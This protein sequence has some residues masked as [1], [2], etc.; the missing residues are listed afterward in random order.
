[1]AKGNFFNNNEIGG[2]LDM[3]SMFG[4]E[5][6][7][8]DSK[9]EDSAEEEAGATEAAEDKGADT[10]PSKP[11]TK[12]SKGTKTL[13]GPVQVLA[14]GWSES[15]GEE[16]KKYSSKE[17]VKLAYE[18]GYREVA[19]ADIK[20]V[21]SENTIYVQTVAS[22]CTDEDTAV[23]D[24]TTIILG[25]NA[26]TITAQQCGLDADELSVYDINEKF[27]SLCP[28]FKGCL[29]KYNPSAK[30]AIP[31]FS[32]KIDGV[33]KIEDGKTYRVWNSD[34]VKEMSSADLKTFYVDYEFYQSESGVLFAMPA[35][36]CGKGKPIAVRVTVLW[37]D[38]GLEHKTE[39]KVK[40]KYVL[41]LTICLA[42]FNQRIS[43]DS[44]MFSGKEK[45]EREDVLEFLKP[46]YR[47][48]RSPSRKFDLSYNKAT[49][50]L[51]VMITSGEKG[52]AACA[53]ASF[54]TPG[55]R[56]EKTPVG[57]FKGKTEEGDVVALD[58]K[59]SLPP[60]PYDLLD[61]IVSIFKADLTKESIVQIYWNEEKGYYLQMPEYTASKISVSYI[62]PYNPDVLVMTVHSHNT[63]R[64]FFSPVDDA[65]EIYTGLFGVIGRLNRV[66]SEMRFR[67][68]M[69][70]CFTPVLAGDI[71]GGGVA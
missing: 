11:K 48:F 18:A 36:P 70:G 38:L 44:S 13:T 55:V 39:E 69:E 63:M 34:G 57:V 47:V 1:M 49:N 37:Q 52:A 35:P 23:A 14:C 9:A 53:A 29:L 7:D 32:N 26:A 27:V 22:S 24:G 10:K 4:I 61:E 20:C 54:T 12:A 41:P 16:G 17:I 45:I 42:A 67:A 6:P 43:V 19:C 40:E 33:E 68:G 50:E 56:V 31:V 21:E 2:Q 5:S 59:F 65:D 30:V 3:L 64:A 58:F 71:F 28:D 46:Q 66:C 15:Y 25:Q 62:F 51:A 8:T 60:I